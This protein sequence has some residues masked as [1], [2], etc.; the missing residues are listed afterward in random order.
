MLQ[1]EINK[2][3]TEI[4]VLLN[5]QNLIWPFFKTM[6][7]KR[8]VI[9]INHHSKVVKAKKN[10]IQKA[11]SHHLCCSLLHNKVRLKVIHQDLGTLDNMFSFSCKTALSSGRWRST[12][13][14]IAHCVCYKTSD[15][16]CPPNSCFPAV[17]LCASMSKLSFWG[18]LICQY[19][20]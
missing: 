12:K 9:G 3:N 20:Q 19:Y 7:R 2:K 4:K 10:S 11:G 5:T 16:A 6:Y 1:K 18:V 15:D 13:P 14:W 17:C 8:N